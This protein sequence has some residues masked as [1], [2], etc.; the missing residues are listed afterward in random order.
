MK[1]EIGEEI[2]RRCDICGMNMAHKVVEGEYIDSIAFICLG[3]N[4]YD[5]EI[6]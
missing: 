5:E 2:D 3:C 4:Q 1:H 6:V